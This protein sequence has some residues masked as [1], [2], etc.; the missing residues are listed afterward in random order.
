M[1]APP[2]PILR[3]YGPKQAISADMFNFMLS[4]QLSL[5]IREDLDE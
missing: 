5:S 1:E 4:G 3:L 2:L